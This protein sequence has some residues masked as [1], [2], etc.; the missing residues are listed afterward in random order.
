MIKNIG[1]QHLTA[2]DKKHIEA[3]FKSGHTSSKINNS[4]WEVMQGT[5]S[6]GEYK[7]RKTKRDR[8]LGFIG[9]QLR[10]SQ[11]N[12]ELEPAYKVIS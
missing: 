9:E 4:L 8:G 2:T 12:D 11:Y 3:L 5:P 7:L 1:K 10:T 6:T